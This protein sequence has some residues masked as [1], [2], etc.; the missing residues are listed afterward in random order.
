MC[1]G[2]CDVITSTT[3]WVI[4]PVCESW[5]PLWYNTWIA[6]TCNRCYT[7][8]RRWD[9]RICVAN[10]RFNMVA[11]QNNKLTMVCGKPCW[12]IGSPKVFHLCAARMKYVCEHIMNFANIYPIK[13][14]IVPF[15]YHLNECYLEIS[16]HG[17]FVNATSRSLPSLNT[18]TNTC[19]TRQYLKKCF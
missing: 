17:S 5:R 3:N 19:M 10:A 14:V 1:H 8:D 12:L 16:L 13:V 6:S 15:I 18:S 4:N 11:I 7:S 2:Q 9:G